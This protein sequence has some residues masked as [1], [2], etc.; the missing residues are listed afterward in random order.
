MSSAISGLSFLTFLAYLFH[1]S[2]RACTGFDNLLYQLN[3]MI[4]IMISYPINPIVL[5]R[6]FLFGN[7]LKSISHESLIHT[8]LS[9]I[10][11]E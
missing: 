3:G 10:I 1:C 4:E 11:I 9:Q 8:V 7:F 5:F 6:E 2:V